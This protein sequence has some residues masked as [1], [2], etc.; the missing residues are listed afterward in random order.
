MIYIIIP[1]F[2]IY[3]LVIINLGVECSGSTRNTVPGIHL[4]TSDCINRN[5]LKSI[6]SKSSNLPLRWGLF[7]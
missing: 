1:V 3:V 6:L 4:E 7:Q 5:V 2:I